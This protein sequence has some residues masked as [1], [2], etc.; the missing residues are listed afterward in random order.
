MLWELT[1]AWKNRRFPRKEKETQ[2]K[3]GRDIYAII[4]NHRFAAEEMLVKTYNPSE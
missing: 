4:S 2:H 3:I 1:Y